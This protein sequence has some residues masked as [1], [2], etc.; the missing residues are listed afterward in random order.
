MEM[1]GFC[2]AP[3]DLSNEIQRDVDKEYSEKISVK[4]G[5]HIKGIRVDLMP[6]NGVLQSLWLPVSPEG[7]IQFENSKDPRIRENIYFVARNGEWYA[8]AVRPLYFEEEDSQPCHEIRLDK[9]HVFH[10]KNAGESYSCYYRYI[11]KEELLFENYQIFSQIR[12]GYGENNDIVYR[13]RLLG[14]KVVHIECRNN[15]LYISGDTDNVW[16]NEKKCTDERLELGDV[17]YYWGLTIVAGIGFI[18]VNDGISNV[19]VKTDRLRKLKLSRETGLY[20]LRKKTEKEET[21]YN[22]LPRRRELF[23]PQKISI[24]APPMSLNNNQIPLMLRMGGTMV[25]SGAS[26]LSG[27]YIMLLSSVLFPILTQKYT[28]KEKQEYEEK[29][30]AK[31]RQY[32]QQKKNEIDRE[33]TYEEQTLRKQYPV[34][35]DV[36]AYPEAGKRLWERRKTDDDFLNIRIGRGELPMVSQIEYPAQHFNMEEDILEHEMRVVAEEKV[37]LQNV[38]IQV[39]FLQNYISA[40][41][42]N[43][44]LTYSFVK[45]LLMM[46]SI[47][48]SYDELKIIVLAEE[49]DLQQELEFVKYIPHV[50]DDQ[51]SVRYIA[52]DTGGAYQISEILTGEVE[53]D[54]K[55]PRELKEILKQHP[56][57]V[58]Y[59]LNKRIFD[60]M[61]ILKELMQQEKNCGVSI[62]TAFEDMPKESML[63][64]HIK[65]SGFNS[66]I[67]LK[68]SSKKD[69]EFHMDRFETELAEKSMK[70]VANTC[71]KNITQAYSL[72]KMVTFLEM[73]RAGKI[74][75]LNVTKRW[76]ENNPVQS[77]AVPVGI[78]TDG[79]PFFLDLHQK[80]QGPHG[81]VAGTTGSGKSEFLLTYILSMAIN[82][83]PDEVAFVLI[84]YKGGGLAG[85]FD[86]T[87]K[88]IHLPHLVG[89]ITNLDG[90]SIQR[91]L[92]SIQSE[93]KRRQRLFNE[94]KSLSDEGT[95]DIYTY[96]RLHRNGTIAEPM[97]HLFIISDEFAELKQ[98]QPD[99]M[100]QLISAA[101][102]GRSLGV[103]LILATQKPA[104]VVNEQI[105]SNT[106]FRVCLKVQDKSDSDDMLK[107]PD[108]AELKDTGRFYLQVGYNEYFALGQ[109]AWSGA[110]YEPKEEV[111]VRKDES[112]QVID[113]IGQT[114]SEA[115]PA[116]EKSTAMGT[117]LV[118]IVK[119]LT[120]LSL[121]QEIKVRQLWKPALQKKID[122]EEI[123][124]NMPYAEEI[125]CNLG[126]MDDPENQEQYPLTYNFER[127]QHLLIVG[128]SGSGKSTLLQSMVFCLC[129]TYSP[130]QINCYILDYSSRMLKRFGVL[131]HCGAVL[132][133]ED[134]DLLDA[135]FELLNG[136]VAERKRKF[137]AWGVDN[138]TAAKQIENIPLILVF[139]DNISG[140]GTSD[141]GDQHLYRLQNYMKDGLNYGIKYIVTC[142]HLN[143]MSTRLRQEFG[144][145][146]SFHARDKYEYGDILGCR[147]EYTPPE[148]PGRGLVVEEGRPL[149]VQTAM[150]GAK[151]TDTEKNVYV[152]EKITSLAEQ[153][154]M[155][156]RA[157]R[158]KITSDTVS[159]D[160]FSDQFDR[161]RI[162]LG[163][164]K[165]NQKAIALPLRQLSTLSVYL[166]KADGTTLILENF[167]LAIKRN[168]GELWFVQ[169]KEDSHF[170]ACA[171][172]ISPGFCDNVRLIVS[173][174]EALEKLW[175][176]MADE[177]AGRIELRNTYWEKS[178]I[179]GG[180]EDKIEQAWD[181]MNTN[182][183]P[184]FIVIENQAEFCQALDSIAAVVF[185]RL[186]QA[187]RG[188]NVYLLAFYAAD[189]PETVKTK[190]LYTDFDEQ[191]ITMLFGGNYHRQVLAEL[192]D[193]VSR[194]ENNI[195]FNVCLMRYRN[196]FHVLTMPC[197]EIVQA[198]SDPDS[199]NI[200]I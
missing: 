193:E 128:E 38:P 78:A 17:V 13:N 63:Q 189:D 4:D 185:G 177:M 1:K 28:D 109:S 159:Y 119:M 108:A 157:K 148:Y 95:M 33:K 199:Q 156:G 5:E 26:A 196:Q 137:S 154:A 97:P 200:F 180:K 179:S 37:I 39:N 125:S 195:P 183:K 3:D 7:K 8:C 42:G 192:P 82:Y 12:I 149:E 161:N 114:I 194:V 64:F 96:Q 31:Y 14:N 170:T 133:E 116:V 76:K 165:K 86:D 24:E 100:E 73:Y 47:L 10:I 49:K 70:K 126:L 66:V 173:E 22:R 178:N 151:L 130:Q 142:G 98:Q 72:P 23:E 146:L 55:K 75:H 162:P 103:H 143:E 122:I 152:T 65:S 41:V 58:I 19:T 20:S 36:L 79:S 186:F 68:D 91:S 134:T 184:L 138:Y 21:L 90:S 171:E 80:Y 187:L 124:D 190:Q 81:L 84:D 163:V 56:Y 176:E 74:E 34:L 71:L 140:L 32:L 132:L 111:V 113:S 105:R 25:M 51:K 155:D 59:A 18:A 150:I 106:K 191:Q 52:T 93:L 135:F 99:F 198:E 16:V 77:L 85:A 110:D 46:M 101:R 197:G 88:G 104:G 43:E 127:S 121:Q 112:V 168:Q 83:H 53:G 48:H 169:K 29:R 30:L 181:Y 11:K 131:P 145:R 141:T 107:R 160:V 62:I 175:H 27:N 174:K 120:D 136:I 50:W 188:L 94:A 129:H 167:L 40:I 45:R 6:E 182:T 60:S 139:I 44:Q 118:A 61:E 164:S 153:T 172:N 15:I 115:R 117:Q 166:G 92:I 57:Y 35:N 102:I 144:H 147:V 9:P 158:L 69:I 67:H 2:A 89:T 87:E 54:V 123:N